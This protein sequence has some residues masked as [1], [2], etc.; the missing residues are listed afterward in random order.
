MY[1]I[2]LPYDAIC[3]AGAVSISLRTAL[4]GIECHRDGSAWYVAA[5]PLPSLGGP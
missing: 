5:P 2:S 1:V 4:T 3:L